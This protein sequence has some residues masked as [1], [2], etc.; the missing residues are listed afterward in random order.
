MIL[1]SNL[2]WFNT[3]TANSFRADE[4]QIKADR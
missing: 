3:Y 4:P 1:N 2:Q